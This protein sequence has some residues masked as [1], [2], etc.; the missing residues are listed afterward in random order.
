MSLRLKAVQ[1]KDLVEPGQDMSAHGFDE[2]DG[3][4]D[5]GAS[6]NDEFNDTSS[7]EDDGPPAD[8]GDELDF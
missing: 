4:E 5:D 2:V 1:V 6:S 7:P 3:F 8:D